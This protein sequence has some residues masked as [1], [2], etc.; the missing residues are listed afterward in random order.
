MTLVMDAKD[1]L[2][3]AGDNDR[4]DFRDGKAPDQGHQRARLPRG[5]PGHGVQADRVS[6]GPLAHG[7]RTASRRPG[8]RRSDLHQRQDR[9]T[10]RRGRSSRSRL[11]DLDPQVLTIAQR[12][13][14]LDAHAAVLCCCTPPKR[15]AHISENS[16]RPGWSY[17]DSNPRPLACHADPV[18][19]SAAEG[20]EQ[21][22]THQQQ[23][24]DWVAVR[25][26]VPEYG[27]S[28]FWLPATQDEGDDG[29]RL[30]RTL[31]AGRSRRIGIR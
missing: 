1:T 9:R 27:G 31:C 18:R 6:P 29:D 14:A 16:L 2:I 19:R 26:R 10:T 3:K 4:V 23:L 28:R 20:V 30:R 13:D 17:G 8:P 11:K 12:Q 15:P 22:A 25:P 5:R 7:Q 24:S 21:G